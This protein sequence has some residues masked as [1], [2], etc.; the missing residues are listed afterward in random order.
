[1]N[2]DFHY[3]YSIHK[4]WWRVRLP[5]L[6]P[7]S[8]PLQSEPWWEFG[9]TILNNLDLENS[10]EGI[11]SS[12]PSQN[13]LLAICLFSASYHFQSHSSKA[14]SPN[15]RGPWLSL[16]AQNWNSSEECLVINFMCLLDWTTAA[17]DVNMHNAMYFCDKFHT[18]FY[19]RLTCKSVHFK[20][21]LFFLLWVGLLKSEICRFLPRTKNYL[22]N[23]SDYKKDDLWLYTTILGFFFLHL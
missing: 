23:R 17:R 10:S 9:V 11:P 12:T 2:C 14:Y 5:N 16:G 1:M 15:P 18:C 22:P 13:S 19:L 8:H 20:G 3:Y 4:E 21:R 7:K 6:S